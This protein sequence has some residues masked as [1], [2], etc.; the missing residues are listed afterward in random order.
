MIIIVSF[1]PFPRTHTPHA[2]PH[3]QTHKTHHTHT[4]ANTPPP[5]AAAAAITEYL[6]MHPI[7]YPPDFTAFAGLKGKKRTRGRAFANT[8]KP[9]FIWVSENLR[10]LRWCHGAEKD[11]ADSEQNETFIEIANIDSVKALDSNG[12]PIAK[13]N[14]IP[15]PASAKGPGSIQIFDISDPS[16][17]LKFDV[18]I[19]NR[20]PVAFALMRLCRGDLSYRL[21][22][23]ERDANTDI[24][25]HWRAE[26][27]WFPG[28]IAG[29]DDDAHE[30]QIQFDE[31]GKSRLYDLTKVFF[32]IERLPENRR[33]G[34]ALYGAQAKAG[35]FARAAGTVE[36]TEETKV[37]TTT[38][39][40]ESS[41]GIDLMAGFVVCGC[42]FA[43]A[44]ELK[45]HQ[46]TFHLQFV[47]GNCGGAEPDKFENLALL[48]E[49]NGGDHPGLPVRQ[50]KAGGDGA[51]LD[52]GA[53]EQE[54][55]VEGIRRLK[56]VEAIKNKHKEELDAL[57]KA[58]ANE[59]SRQLAKIDAQHAEEL[60]H[61]RHDLEVEKDKEL[62]LSDRI[63]RIQKE[64]RVREA[65]ARDNFT[66]EMS[67]KDAMYHD[68]SER[69]KAVHA[70]ALAAMQTELDRL[71]ERS[72][73]K[74][75]EHHQCPQK[76]KDAIFI[77][78]EAHSKEIAGL[79]EAHAL[80]LE[81]ERATHAVESDRVEKL[82]QAFR[83]SEDAREKE[84]QA[85]RQ[86][87]EGMHDQID[88][89]NRDKAEA[90]RA[91]QASAAKAI[92]DEKKK[93]AEAARL[94][95]ATESL[96]RA[97]VVREKE[98]YAIFVA[99]AERE[100]ASREGFFE[101]E[102]ARQKAAWEDR[103]ASKDKTMGDRL[104]A[105]QVQIHQLRGDNEGLVLQRN[106]A[107]EQAQALKMELEASSAEKDRAKKELAELQATHAKTV[108]DAESSA[109]LH[110]LEQTNSQETIQRL[111]DELLA[112]ESKAKELEAVA[113]EVE[114][115]KAK[116][117]G[118]SRHS[119]TVAHSDTMMAGEAHVSSSDD[120]ADSGDE[121]SFS[122]ETE[123]AAVSSAGPVAA[124][125]PCQNCAT[126]ESEL[127]MKKDALEDTQKHLEE[128]TARSFDLEEQLKEAENARD[129]KAESERF[130]MQ[131][132]NK[133]AARAEE[134]EQALV[135]TA[136]K[137]EDSEKA[138]TSLENE[139]VPGLRDQLSA[140][141]RALAQKEG[142]FDRLQESTTA[143]LTEIRD[144]SRVA[145]ESK[146]RIIA[147]KQEEISGCMRI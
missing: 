128:I 17:V 66:A 63:A 70:A 101:K 137:L 51:A 72:R 125:E 131:R 1:L 7:C 142:D 31:D 59:V 97:Q 24:S 55:K 43:T 34:G 109:K 62:A 8:T 111:Q 92:A 79:R 16:R 27:Q 60:E 140:A 46:E 110:E 52:F 15:I 77:V 106:E 20:D 107:F 4:C 80:A 67:A 35:A 38:T 36:V 112:A 133:A 91:A 47:C 115:A 57:S 68:L 84:A 124:P 61:L 3:T 88:A 50:R 2:T 100:K 144:E 81:R 30:H 93:G 118:F 5:P 23:D 44:L 13:R 120:D 45:E 90:V 102:Q 145:L 130:E 114:T 103:L 6:N 134:A 9:K 39:T 143:A 49:H 14:A 119:S 22:W 89:V 19:Q 147:A 94:A 12:R 53:K 99:G 11:L 83:D 117:T 74:D 82:Q 56:S 42:R 95:A 25:I 135:S 108:M 32:R 65:T 126:L 69:E 40:T 71:A 138:R 21:L 141:Q 123:A 98:A 41:G 75:L 132:A 18:G 64:A 73:A 10:F 29:F 113:A 78:H 87:L 85:S 33:V 54:I 96:W 116:N 129:K 86:A 76:Q 104:S 139:T 26:D 48:T 105:L 37:F 146:D 58:K 121:F 28:K 127:G 122:V 136:T